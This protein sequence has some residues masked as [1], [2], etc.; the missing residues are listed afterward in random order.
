MR[1]CS[2]HFDT[3]SHHRFQLPRHLSYGIPRKLVQVVCFFFPGKKKSI[4]ELP[5]CLIAERKGRMTTGVFEEQGQALT[6]K[7][8]LVI[9]SPSNFPEHWGVSNSHPRKGYPRGSK[10]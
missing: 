9:G 8:S 5:M 7:R 4:H 3:G 2:A 6:R 1:F 10:V